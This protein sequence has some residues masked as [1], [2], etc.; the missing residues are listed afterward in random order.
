MPWIIAAV[1]V[2]IFGLAALAATGKLGELPKPDDD[3]YAP[4]LPATALTPDDL[5]KLTFG[6][7][8]RGYD[9]AQVDAVL[10]RLA[11]ELETLSESKNLVTAE[12]IAAESDSLD[13]I[14][15]QDSIDGDPLVLSEEPISPVIAE[16]KPKNS[17]DCTVDAG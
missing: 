7:T 5:R 10:E 6:V 13:K 2:L 4:T 15:S 12:T 3:T 8:V 1:A 16:S 14:P 9:M 11:S 17:S